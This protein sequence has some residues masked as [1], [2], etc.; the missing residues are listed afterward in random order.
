MHT[1]GILMVG[2]IIQVIVIRMN[3]TAATITPPTIN[4]TSA[5]INIATPTN[6]N[7]PM[8][9]I[10]ILL[11]QILTPATT[12]I[13]NITIAIIITMTRITGIPIR[14]NI[15]TPIQLPHLS[16]QPL[17]NLHIP[18]PTATNITI[19]TTEMRTC[20]AFTSTSSPTPSDP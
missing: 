4:H 6:H 5:M 16:L 9:I 12:M 19:T 20:T 2:M 7:I 10:L 14:T 3:R 1:M 11:T 17:H 15:A 18:I 13:L 8:L